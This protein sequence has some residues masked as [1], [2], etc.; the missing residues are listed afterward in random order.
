M[1]EFYRQGDVLIVKV[2]ELPA[3]IKKAK[4][5]VIIYGETTGHSHRVMGGAVVYD[6]PQYSGD[7]LLKLIEVGN[8]EKAQVVHEEHG[9]IDLSPGIYECRRQRE[10]GENE[11]R[12]VMD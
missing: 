5:N 4:D 1:Q 11:I 7:G 3:N 6:P 8:K 10:Y 2:G 9:T 12:Y